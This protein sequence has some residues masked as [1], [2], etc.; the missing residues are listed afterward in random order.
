VFATLIGPYPEI[1][2]ASDE[3]RLVAVIGD[4]LE[5]GLGLLSDGRIHR[6]EPGTS[7]VIDAWRAA[8]EV[9]HRLAADLGL[10]P[11]FIKACLLGPWSAGGGAPRAVEEA[12]DTLLPTIEGLFESGAPVVQLTEPGIGDIE[13][14]DEPAITVVSRALERLATPFA[15]PDRHLSLALAGGGP[16]RVPP[17]RLLVG[18]SSCLL[19]PIASPDDWN[20][21]ARVPGSAGLIVGVVD[22]RAARAGAAE[23][24]VWG[25]RYAASMGGRGAARTGICPGAGLERLDRAGARALLAFTAD[26]ARKAELPDAQLMREVDPMAVDARSAALGS[27]EPRPRRSRRPSGP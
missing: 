16:T 5:A 21:C 26:V 12:V 15:T 27:A 6:C 18:F 3:V 19:D 1:E 24:G 17:E 9:G 14:S 8:D 10:E 22:A 2:G 20:V 13:S 23:V 11:P 4:Q 25:A 7:A